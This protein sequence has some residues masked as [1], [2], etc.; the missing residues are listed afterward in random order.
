M[1]RQEP[2][3]GGR[4]RGWSCSSQRLDG[5]EGSSACA[6]GHSRDP[7][8]AQAQGAPFPALQP[9]LCPAHPPSLKI[10]AGKVPQTFLGCTDGTGAAADRRPHNPKTAPGV[11]SCSCSTMWLPDQSCLART[12]LVKAWLLFP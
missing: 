10:R 5:S 4:G 8:P 11:N 7:C 1:T 9:F 6:Q 2:S 12:P 3:Q